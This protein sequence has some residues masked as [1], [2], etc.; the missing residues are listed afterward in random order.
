MPET[1][2][3]DTLLPYWYSQVTFWTH[4]CY[5]QMSLNPIGIDCTGFCLGLTSQSVFQRLEDTWAVQESHD[6]AARQRDMGALLS[7][8]D[9]FG[10]VFEYFWIV[11]DTIFA[12]A[13]T[14]A[15]VWEHMLKSDLPDLK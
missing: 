9:R 3:G 5:F 13:H 1:S 11:C 14:P 15:H 10:V 4:L 6:L 7:S 8:G 2:L 12:L